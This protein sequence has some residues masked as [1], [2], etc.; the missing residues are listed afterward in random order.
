[1]VLAFQLFGSLMENNPVLESS[2]TQENMEKSIQQVLGSFG[3][4]LTVT[5]KEID[6]LISRTTK[7]VASGLNQALH[8]AISPQ[9]YALYL[10]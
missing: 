2:I 3:T 10:Q 4:S 5:P 7:V 1:M 9:D 8:V 6:E